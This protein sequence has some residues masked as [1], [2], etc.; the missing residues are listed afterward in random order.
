[1]LSPIESRANIA[2]SKKGPAATPINFRTA[3]IQASGA[4]EP[5]HI[6]S[7]QSTSRRVGRDELKALTCPL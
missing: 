2:D 3:T 1:M 4:R 5:G 7:N 6:S